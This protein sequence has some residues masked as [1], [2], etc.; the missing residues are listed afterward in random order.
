MNGAAA[1]A[2]IVFSKVALADAVAFL[3]T[4]GTSIGALSGAEE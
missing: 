1:G 4:E 3:I 2:N